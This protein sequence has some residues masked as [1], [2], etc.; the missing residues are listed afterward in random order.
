MSPIGF[1]QT[2]GGIAVN[3]AGV[4]FNIGSILDYI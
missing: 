3:K 2:I 4:E 1:S